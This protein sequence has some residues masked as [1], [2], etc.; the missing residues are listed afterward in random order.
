M[1]VG[2]ADHSHDDN[3]DGGIST[4]VCS[5]TAAAPPV[6]SITVAPETGSSVTA[7]APPVSSITVAPATGSSVTAAAPPVS[8]ITVA[9]A[10]ESSVTAAAPPVSSITVAPSTESLQQVRDACN[11]GVAPATESL[12]SQP[13]KEFTDNVNILG[14]LD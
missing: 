8:S 5:V 9:P 7:A 14:K 11:R 6:S 10:T 13:V 3:R 1:H 12:G 2:Q 4:P